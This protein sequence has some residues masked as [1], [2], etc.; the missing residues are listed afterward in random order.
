[1]KKL[2]IILW[3]VA[4]TLALPAREMVKNGNFQDGGQHWRVLRQSGLNS[5]NTPVSFAGNRYRSVLPQRF[6]DNNGRLQ[7]VQS[8]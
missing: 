8:M 4:T 3:A 1:M 2:F 6:E 5:Q 7:L